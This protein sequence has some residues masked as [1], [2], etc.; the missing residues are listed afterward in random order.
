MRDRQPDWFRED[1]A[2]L[3]D[4]LGEGRIKPIVAEHLPWREARRA[5]ELLEQGSV[6]GKIVLTFQN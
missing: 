1:L 5:N 3:F 2:T 4:L 6:Q